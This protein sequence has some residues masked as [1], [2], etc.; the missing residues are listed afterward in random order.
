M[1]TTNT[2][3]SSIAIAFQLSEINPSNTSWACSSSVSGS[4]SNQFIQP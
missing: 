1:Q 3:Y 2:G 4:V